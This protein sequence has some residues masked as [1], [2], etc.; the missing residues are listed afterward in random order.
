MNNTQIGRGMA[1]RST[2]ELVHDRE[3]DD[4]AGL[5]VE[6]ARAEGADR[7]VE[8]ERHPLE[9]ALGPDGVE[10]AQDQSRAASLGP[11]SGRA[12]GRPLGVG[13][14]LDGTRPAIAQAVRQECCQ[15]VERRLVAAGRLVSRPGLQGL[16]MC[17]ERF[18]A[19]SEIP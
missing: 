2:F 8:A 13:D 14:D 19:N 12:C 18:A 3:E 10:V 4:Q 16:S 11:G 6:D 17:V 5:H 15:C 9:R 7:F 1:C